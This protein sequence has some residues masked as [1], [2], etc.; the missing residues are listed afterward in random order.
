MC[1]KNKLFKKL[2]NSSVVILER[3]KENKIILTTAPA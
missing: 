2:G 1:E 3:Q